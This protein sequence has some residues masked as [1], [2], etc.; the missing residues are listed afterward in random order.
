MSYPSKSYKV[1]P[2]FRVLYSSIYEVLN[3]NKSPLLDYYLDK[4]V[5]EV[6]RHRLS[7]F[8][9]NDL[10]IEMINQMDD[11]L[12]KTNYDDLSLTIFMDRRTEMLRKAYRDTQN[13]PENLTPTNFR[14]PPATIHQVSKMKHETLGNVIELAT[15]NYAIHLP[16]IDFELMFIVYQRNLESGKFFV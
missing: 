9:Y 10:I 4:A 7:Q 2:M 5:G 8:D 16:E 14:V 13:T 12:S 3:R 1:H 11:A 15:L 6:E